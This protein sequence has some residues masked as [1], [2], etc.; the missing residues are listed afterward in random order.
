MR[1]ISLTDYFC[2]GLRSSEKS[3]FRFSDDLSFAGCLALCGLWNSFDTVCEGRAGW[4][5]SSPNGN[6]YVWRSS[7]NFVLRS[8][9]VWKDERLSREKC[10]ERSSES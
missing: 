3:C 4:I 5:F 8:C 2:K 9:V 10:E 7:E 1:Q 6:D